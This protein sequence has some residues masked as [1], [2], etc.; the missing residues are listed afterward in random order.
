[1]P[2]ATASFARLHRLVRPEIAAADP[3]V[4]YAN[5]GVRGLDQVGVGDPLDTDVPGAIH[6]GCAHRCWHRSETFGRR[7]TWWGIEA[8]VESVGSEALRNTLAVL[9]EPIS[10]FQAQTEPVASSDFPHA[11]CGDTSHGSG[12]FPNAGPPE[13]PLPRLR[14]SARLKKKSRVAA[15]LR[16][17]GEGKLVNCSRCSPHSRDTCNSCP[18]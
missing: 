4:S 8:F 5:E 9:T 7:G 2:H 3:G 16:V 1:V 15:A 6:D 14:V 17:I 10:G 12:A 18:S 11:H 13:D